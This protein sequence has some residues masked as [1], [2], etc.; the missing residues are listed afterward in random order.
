MPTLKF[1]LYVFNRL[2]G[3]ATALL[4]LFS[5]CH[6]AGVPQ[7]N[8]GELRKQ[9][10]LIV[11]QYKAKVGLALRHIEK[12]DTLTLNNSRHYPMQSVY[13][14]PLALAVLE[15]VDK[16]QLS[17]S[18]TYRLHKNDL[19]DDTWSPM[20]IKYPEGNVDLSLA[21][22]LD[23]SVS[24]SD[25]IACDLLFKMMKGTAPVNDYIHRLGFKDIEIRATEQEMH[26]SEPAQ[27][28]NWSRPMTL[29]MILEKFYQKKI[30]SDSSHRFL[31]RLMIDS[32]NDPARIK[33]MLPAETAVAHK[34]GTGSRRGDTLIACNDVGIITM[35]D[36]G[37]LALSV[38]VTQSAE[39]YEA[40][41]E[42]IARLSKCVYDFYFGKITIFFEKG[43][44]VSSDGDT[45]PYRLLA[46]DRL[47]EGQTY[48]LLI[49]LHG[50]GG[51]GR[52][53]EAPVKKLHPAFTDSL[54]RAQY[55]CYVLVPQCPATDAWAL[56]PGFPQSL[57]G[58]QVPSA[59]AKH[60]LALIR[61]LVK[62]RR[63]DA[64]R[65]YLTGYSLGGEGTFDL[66]MRAP[67]LFACGVPIASV[68]D[69][70]R[71]KQ[72]VDIPLWAFHGSADKINDVRYTRLMIETMKAGGG[73]PK[74]TEV[75][76]APHDC[77]DAAYGSPA[78]WKWMFEQRK[79]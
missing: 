27:Y 59:A 29:C 46:P 13:K 35:P 61:S 20:K 15:A 32:Q 69:T 19:L 23:Y 22:L 40:T 71:A 53:N 21:Q 1:P 25:N 66:L 58:T 38:L 79:K 68:G 44:F 26:R 57:A 41:R 50:S 52:D 2:T 36:G 49:Y 3:G 9:L 30:L 77:R 34:T 18:Q 39:T 73:K 47:T 51:R 62:S 64:S 70:A 17:L 55:P 65:I 37:H 16:G 42:L 24:K 28:E 11:S 60:T 76:G 10:L 75:A 5:N 48:P 56:F 78:L 45:L 7:K 12:G 72:I 8:N 4:L 74:Y 31:M 63:V 54:R 43:A 67:D 6:A 33:G 14:F